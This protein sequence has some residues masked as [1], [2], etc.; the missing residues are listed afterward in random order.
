MIMGAYSFFF[1]HIRAPFYF[2]FVCYN[3][4]ICCIFDCFDQNVYVN[5]KEKKKGLQM[6]CTTNTC[7]HNKNVVRRYFCACLKVNFNDTQ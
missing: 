7:V 5:R 4:I 6:N 1:P 2:F 3:L